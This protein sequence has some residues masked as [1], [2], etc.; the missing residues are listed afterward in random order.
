MSHKIDYSQISKIHTSSTATDES[1]FDIEGYS[2]PIIISESESVTLLQEYDQ[3][4]AS[5]P[6]EATAREITRLVLDALKKFK[7]G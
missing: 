4:D 6:S 3:A 7:E 5:S 2:I 1:S